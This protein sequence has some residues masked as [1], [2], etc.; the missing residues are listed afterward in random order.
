MV[1]LRIYPETTLARLARDAGLI[2]ER[3]PL[4]EPRF[5]AA[6]HDRRRPGDDVAAAAGAGGGGAAPELVP[7][8]RARLERGLWTAAAAALRQGRTAVAQLP[9]ASLVPLRVTAAGAGADR[10]REA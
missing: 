9:A 6:G 3:Q 2:G 8:R 4:L 10:L 1:G 5:Y 7:P